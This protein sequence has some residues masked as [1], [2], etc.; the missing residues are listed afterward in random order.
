[1]PLFVQERR[2]CGHR[3]AAAAAALGALQ[4]SY[5]A[6]DGRTSVCGGNG[7]AVAAPD[8]ELGHLQ[9]RA[10]GR[11]AGVSDVAAPLAAAAA[12]AALRC[13]R[14]DAAAVPGSGWQLAMAGP[15]QAAA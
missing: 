8:T 11:Q 2:C 14:P 6:A 5:A 1:M 9:R 3:T 10:T 7:A 13:R 15:R 12:A 4:A